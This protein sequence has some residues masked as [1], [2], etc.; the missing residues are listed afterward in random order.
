LREPIDSDEPA[1][2]YSAIVLNRLRRLGRPLPFR[3]WPPGRP[4]PVDALTD[5]DLE[6]VNDLLPW[7]CFTVDAHGRRL[8]N[9]AWV[10]KRDEPQPLPDPRITLMDERWSLSG[11]S[12]LEVGCFEG[13]H[14]I[15]LM[16]TGA[17]VVAL[18]S[19]AENV[20]KTAARCAV[21]GSEPR[22]L[23]RDLERTDALDDIDCE[24]AHHVG[25]LYHLADP[26]GHLVELG[27]RVS[28]GIMLDTHIGSDATAT[29]EAAGQTWS[30]Q[31]YREGGRADPFSGMQ[32]EAKWLPLPALTDALR[33]AGF[34]QVDVAEQRDERNGQRV[35]LF[36]DR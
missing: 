14:T 19:R 26:V 5:D 11:R 35:L 1:D 18:D 24:F 21:Y 28:R 31:P 4:S 17:T 9:R 16:W 30:Y 15:G 12:V 20:V 34:T 10:G 3:G 8:G 27:R 32:A 36:A 7:K 13:V 6:L 25:V 2:P 29:Y 22:L 23:V 33:L